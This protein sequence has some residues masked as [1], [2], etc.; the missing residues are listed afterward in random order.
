MKTNDKDMP[1]VVACLATWNGEPFIEDTLAS[2]AAQTYPNLKVL[3]SDDASTDNTLAICERF[4]NKDSRFYLLRQAKRS[5]WVGNVNLLLKAARG[6]YFFFVPHDDVLDPN[7]VT[8][9]VE[10]LESRPNAI[11]AFSDMEFIDLSGDVQI[12]TYVELEGVEHRIRRAHR[13]LRQRG[14]WWIPYRG[15]FRATAVKHIGGLKTNLAGEFAADW[16]WLVHMSILGEFVR[17]PEVLYKRVESKKS[18]SRIWDY[19]VRA[20]IAAILACGR[21]IYR[22]RL[23]IFEK[24]LLHVSLASACLRWGRQG[25]MFHKR[26]L[27]KRFHSKPGSRS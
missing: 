5:G 18:L 1:L 3:I 15:I 21:E 17:V 13:M 8:R 14:H 16:P 4:A 24:I 20:W 6:D 11:L 25:L 10:M 7:Y 2:L 26:K 9:L 22:S 19:T 23:S 12:Q 27:F